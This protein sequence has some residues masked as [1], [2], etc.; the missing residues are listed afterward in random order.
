MLKLCELLQDTFH[1][2]D[3]KLGV[4]PILVIENQRKKES[5][6]QKLDFY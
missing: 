5:K 6:S 4:L 1:A 3:L 2:I